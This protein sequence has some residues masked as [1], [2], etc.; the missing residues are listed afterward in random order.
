MKEEWRDIIGYEGLYQVSNLGRV[1]S[2]LYHNGTNERII[3]PI[4]L[5]NGYYNVGLSK[6]KISKRIY[7]HRL[8]ADAFIPNPNN[9]PVIN[10]KD[11]NPSN[12]CVNNLEWCTQKYNM[13]YG[14]LKEKQKRESKSVLQYDLNNNFIKQWNS[15]SDAEQKLNITHCNIVACLKHRRN[16]A[17]GFIW[18]YT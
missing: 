7:I 1:K 10:H 17:G 5:K 4:R 9:Y 14:T 6:N 16:N 11:E 18:K 8:V 3:K 15:I 12:N 2:F 13:N